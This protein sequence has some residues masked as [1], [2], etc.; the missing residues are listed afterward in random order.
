MNFF[1]IISVKLFT[2]NIYV[3]I[4]FNNN[5]LRYTLNHYVT[6]LPNKYNS[7][8]VSGC[9]L[10]TFSSREILRTSNLQPES[11]RL[12]DALILLAKPFVCVISN[13]SITFK[14]SKLNSVE[15]NTLQVRA[16]EILCRMLQE[17]QPRQA[18]TL[19]FQSFPQY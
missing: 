5:H 9:G 4:S 1:N 7:I 2:R 19:H 8:L 6:R 3:Y 16:L 13:S 10:V 18:S 17:L 14:G 11:S 12:S 15:T